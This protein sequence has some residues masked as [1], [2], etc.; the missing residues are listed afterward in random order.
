MQVIDWK[1]PHQSDLLHAPGGVKSYSLLPN[2]SCPRS[3]VKGERFF[4]TAITNL[5]LVSVN[6]FFT[7]FGNNKECLDCILLSLNKG[8][9]YISVAFYVLNAFL[10]FMTTHTVLTAI[11][12]GEPGLAGSRPPCFSFIYSCIL[13][14]Q[15][16]TVHIL[17]GTVPSCISWTTRTSYS[18]S[19]RC[20]TAFDPIFFVVMLVTAL[21]ASVPNN[22]MFLSF[23]LKS[24]VI[25]ASVLTLPC[26]SSLA[27]S[28]CQVSDTTGVYSLVL[29]KI[30]SQAI[31]VSTR[32][33][34]SIQQ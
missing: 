6:L 21:T 20:H 5:L 14:G 34:F 17:F 19:L 31:R 1:N 4:S 26:S 7:S 33:T 15:A 32:R 3:S 30:L 27:K 11:F 9:Y 22:S 8:H 13:S 10:H 16:K 12:P 25:L 23:S 29:M 24:L 28:H 2:P 18:I